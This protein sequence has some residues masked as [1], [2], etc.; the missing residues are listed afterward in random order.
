M[1]LALL[2]LDDQTRPIARAANGSGLHRI[3]LA[4]DLP[5]ADRGQ[6]QAMFPGAEEG[7]WE[8]LLHEGR[9]DAVVVAAAADAAGNELRAEQLRRLAQAGVPML[10]AHPVVDS[11]LVYYELEMLRQ[12]LHCTIVP[13]LPARWSPAA[14]RLAEF[15][16]AGDQ[17][18]IGAIN[19][20]VMEG[21][22]MR[23]G[24]GDVLAQFARDVDVIR[25]VCGDVTRIGAMGSPE[26][27][28]S[29]ANLAV[30]MSGPGPIATRWTVAPAEDIP[31]RRLTIIGSRGKAVLHMPEDGAWRLKIR[32][33]GASQAEVV[34][35]ADWSAPAAAL[36]ALDE[37]ISR[38]PTPTNANGTDAAA[39]DWAQAIRDI[40]LAEG[41]GRSL[42]RGRTIEVQREELSETNT[43]KGLM[44]AF[45]CGIL[46]IAAGLIFGIALLAQIAQVN[47]W[48]WLAD[49]LKSWPWVVLAVLGLFLVFQLL[50]RLADP[51]SGKKPG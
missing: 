11:L 51:P 2:G 46:T 14:A 49:V 17:S 6:M 37:A 48:R 26:P 34:K 3:V 18:P 7:P 10:I 1:R 22:P 47:G 45:G 30:Q 42:R 13:Y 50:L 21:S 32:P 40:E 41:V 28:A 36:E 35:L 23:R 5:P 12:D 4:C 44:T 16:T 39:T 43:F 15:V 27:D 38:Q 20:A 24:R 31:N 8:L 19:Q 29:L 9:I 33:A 25:S